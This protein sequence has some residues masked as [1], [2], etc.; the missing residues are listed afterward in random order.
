MA[1]VGGG[2]GEGVTGRGFAIENPREDACVFSGGRRVVGGILEANRA[3]VVGDASA[4]ALYA[5]DI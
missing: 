3:V 5:D 4:T 2:G 1:A